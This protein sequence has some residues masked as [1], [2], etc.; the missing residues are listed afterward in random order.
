MID[1]DSFLLC[2]LADIFF[3]RHVGVKELRKPQQQTVLQTKKAIN[4][5]EK[6]L[7]KE[8]FKTTQRRHTHSLFTKQSKTHI[9]LFVNLQ[10]TASGICL[11][12][13]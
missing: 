3:A 8:H 4:A 10:I 5:G 13:I 12:R 11:P 6:K 7:L 2:H 1:Y 9:A